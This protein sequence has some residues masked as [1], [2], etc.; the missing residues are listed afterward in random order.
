MRKDHNADDIGL[1]INLCAYVSYVFKW[2]WH[3]VAL[4]SRSERIEF[5]KQWVFILHELKTNV[6]TESFCKMVNYIFNKNCW[7]DKLGWQFF[8]ALHIFTYVAFYI[9]QFATESALP[10]VSTPSTEHSFCLDYASCLSEH[11]SRII[12]SSISM[13]ESCI[14][15]F[16][17]SWLSNQ[18]RN[19]R[20]KLHEF[21]YLFMIR[22]DVYKCDRLPYSDCCA[23]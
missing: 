23:G 21:R 10:R 1:F 15:A 6:K 3:W 14:L 13:T 9:D 22:I 11:L 4:M 12:G 17:S 18:Y 2:P 19:S 7:A 5:Y 20:L 16:V 8:V